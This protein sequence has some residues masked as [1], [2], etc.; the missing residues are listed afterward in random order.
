MKT[1]MQNKDGFTLI[2]ILFVM[3]ITML[4]LAAIYMATSSGQRSSVAI[5]QKVAAQQDARAVLNIMALE[6]GMASYNKGAEGTAWAAPIA[7][8]TSTGVLT[9]PMLGI[10][11]AA[12]D[13]LNIQAD[14]NENTVLSDSNENITY[15]YDATNQMITRNTGGGNQSFLGDTPGTA[16]RSVRVVNNLLNIPLFS[17]FDG[18]GNITNNVQQ[19]RRIDITLIV[20]T[21]RIDP[22][23]GQRRRMVYSTSVIPKNHAINLAGAI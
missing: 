15:F 23:T 13:C 18:S 19:I 4:L 1:Y 9:N 12:S 10:Q 2:E 22:N 14:L 16:S 8:P 17:Y 21:D 3:V 5:E 7:C 11:L 20:E 6:I